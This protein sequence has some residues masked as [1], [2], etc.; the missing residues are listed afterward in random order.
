VL[1]VVGSGRGFGRHSLQV[2]VTKNPSCTTRLHAYAFIFIALLLPPILSAGSCIRPR[3]SVCLLLIAITQ[4]L[5]GRF[6]LNL[7]N[8]ESVVW[9]REHVG[10]VGSVVERRSLADI[11]SLS[12][13]RPAAD[14]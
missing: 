9:S 3:L 6:S 10:G 11:L 14:G 1:Q 4:I 7:Q 13:A 2:V 5:I 12:C 8:I